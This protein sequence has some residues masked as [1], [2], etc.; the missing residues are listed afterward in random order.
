M[1]PVT[2]TGHVGT[3][4]SSSLCMKVIE[5]MKVIQDKNAAYTIFCFVNKGHACLTSDAGHIGHVS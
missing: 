1:G 4:R 2:H 5:A 3:S